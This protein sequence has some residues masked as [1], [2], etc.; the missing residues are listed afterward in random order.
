MTISSTGDYIVS[1]GFGKKIVVRKLQNL[2]VSTVLPKC[3]SSIRS[4]D[5]SH[6]D[7]FVVAGLASGEVVVVPLGLKQ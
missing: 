7:I 6:D 5:L 3:N 1:G 4:L 2:E